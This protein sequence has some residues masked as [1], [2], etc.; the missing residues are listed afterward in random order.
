DTPVAPA[1]QEETR[2]DHRVVSRAR[3]A[4][5]ALPLTTKTVRD[6]GR[7]NVVRRCE[8]SE[9]YTTDEARSASYPT[10]S[11]PSAWRSLM[12]QTSVVALLTSST[13]AMRYRMRLIRSINMAGWKNWRYCP[14]WRVLSRVLFE[15]S[16]E[17]PCFAFEHHEAVW[18]YTNNRVMKR[19]VPV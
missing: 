5:V 17:R 9:A 6:N 7:R 3:C 19:K 13:G 10:L 12:P 1:V 18:P 11:I 14:L 4:S 15:R 8:E 16:I 2:R